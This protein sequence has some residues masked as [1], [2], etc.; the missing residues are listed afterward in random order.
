MNAQ[1]MKNKSKTN[2]E[3]IDAMRDEEIDFTD[4]PELNEA[5]FK[6]AV[7]WPGH[8]KQ[9]TLRIDPDVLDF[10][11]GQGKGYQTTINSV[12]RKYVDAQ[13][14]KSMKK[15]VQRKAGIK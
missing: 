4:S 3:R 12:L 13:R 9:I 2:W 8:K 10:F 7:L 1:N 15:P 5:F 14:G 6:E 11:K